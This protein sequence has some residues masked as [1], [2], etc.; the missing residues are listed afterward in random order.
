IL[1]NIVNNS[2]NLATNTYSHDI[3]AQNKLLTVSVQVSWRKLWV[4]ISRLVL[5]STSQTYVGTLALALQVLETHV[6]KTKLLTM[7]RPR[8]DGNFFDVAFEGVCSLRDIKTSKAIVSPISKE[9][10][11][12]NMRGLKSKL[13][14]RKFSQLAGEI[15]QLLRYVNNDELTWKNPL[16][17]QVISDDSDLVQNGLTILACQTFMKPA[18]CMQPTLPPIIQERCNSFIEHFNIENVDEFPRKLTNTGNWK[19]T[20]EELVQITEEILDILYMFLALHSQS[21]YI[22]VI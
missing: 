20:E 14:V 12:K 19:E 9:E 8:R 6:W 16:A 11:S 17:S 18:Q 2:I 10:I 7:C 22:V 13:S 5:D 4:P 1:R 3:S 21:D 15:R